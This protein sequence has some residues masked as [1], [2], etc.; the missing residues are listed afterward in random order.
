MNPIES[1]LSR[2]PL[3]VLDC[4]LGTEI[5]KR[6]FDTN[7]S[8]WSAKALYERPE[9]I[10]E[11]F[12]EYYDQGADLVATASYQA[13]IP[14][15]EA[16]G[17]SH[18]ESADLIRKSV[19]IA[20]EA[21]DA[22]WSRHSGENRPKPIVAASVGP[23]GAYLAN[24]SEYTGDYS[25]TRKELADFHAERLALLLEE[26]PEIVAIETIPLLREAQAVLDVLKDTPEASAW[27]AFSCKNG[28]ETCGGDSVYEAA[29][30]LDSNP[31]LAAIGI[32]CTAPQY[33][34]SLIQEVRRGTSKP[35][36]CYPNTGES[37]N[38]ATK[39]WFGSPLPFRA[40]VRTWYE[41]GARMIGGCC[42]ATPADTHDIAEFRAELIREG[43]PPA[44]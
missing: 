40:Y 24:G 5:A 26:R 7:D 2:Y 31:Q 22:S 9:L 15:F 11:I 8:L 39:T 10:R 20:R 28:K 29:K 4:A 42:R 38:P 35:I 36:I 44:L 41:A 33:V 18:D 25:L 43:V 14:G 32:N 13:T 3:M 37:Y 19:V 23:Y 16:K 12:E 6:G 27:V 30:A 21:R 34:A 17:F 1:I